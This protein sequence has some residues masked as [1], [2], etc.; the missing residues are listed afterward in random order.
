MPPCAFV[1][2]RFAVKAQ[3]VPG[4]PSAAALEK[5]EEDPGI[6]WQRSVNCGAGDNTA[7][8]PS[9][10]KVQRSAII[11]PIVP[12]GLWGWRRLLLSG[13]DSL[14]LAADMVGGEHLAGHQIQRG[15]GIALAVYPGFGRQAAG[16]RHGVPVA[17][18]QQGLASP[19]AESDDVDEYIGIADMGAN[20]GSDER[21]SRFGDLLG[22]LAVQLA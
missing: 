12:A 11:E 20:L 10:S 16:Q 5:Y 18:R 4:K 14:A 2:D 6:G 22:G 19:L 8:D 1:L 7:P 9:R 15:A 3:F 17:Q 21:F 13:L